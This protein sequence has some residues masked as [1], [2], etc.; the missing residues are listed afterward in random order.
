MTEPRD[1]TC[2]L[3]G[4]TFDRACTEAEAD[5]DAKARWGV[6][7]ATEKVGPPGADTAMVVLCEDCFALRT[8]LPV[9]V[10]ILSAEGRPTSWL[11]NILDNSG[12]VPVFHTALG[13]VVGTASDYEIDGQDIWAM[14]DLE[15][16][17]PD[18][19]RTAGVIVLRGGITQAHRRD[20]HGSESRAAHRAHRRGSPA[21]AQLVALLEDA[22]RQRGDVEAQPLDFVGG[23]LHDARQL[24]I[25]DD[26]AQVLRLRTAVGHAALVLQEDHRLQSVDGE[27]V[28]RLP[29]GLALRRAP[30]LARGWAVAHR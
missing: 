24:E 4:G 3:C 5:A 17:T 27:R 19:K 11:R 21:D 20:V 2:A 10:N 26:A 12:P 18:A 13:R 7:D 22:Q 15:E 30:A 9:R 8:I 1:F 23:L 29:Q 14:L 16:G 28:E 6:D 25:R